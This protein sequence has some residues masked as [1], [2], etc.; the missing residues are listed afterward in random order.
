MQKLSSACAHLV[1]KR[2]EYLHVIQIFYCCSL[3]YCHE[4]DSEGENSNF[5]CR[6]TWPILIC[7]VYFIMWYWPTVCNLGKKAKD[8]VMCGEGRLVHIPMVMIV[9]Q[10]KK[11]TFVSRFHLYRWKN[12]SL[13]K[14]LIFWTVFLM[15][16][17]EH[18]FSHLHMHWL[19]ALLQSICYMY[20]STYLCIR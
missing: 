16:V 13:I 5:P 2:L 17:P 12:W 10:T 3:E 20:V 8:T 4:V 19:S 1:H 6:A 18:C 15:W 9:F 7:N 14:I 11:E